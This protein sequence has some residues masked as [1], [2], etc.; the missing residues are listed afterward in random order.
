MGKGKNVLSLVIKDDLL[1]FGGLFVWIW[2]GILFVCGG[3]LGSGGGCF[4]FG[5]GGKFWL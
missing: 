2:G 5:I 1:L 4:I 3:F